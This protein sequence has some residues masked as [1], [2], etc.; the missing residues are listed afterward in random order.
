MSEM[1]SRLR[2]VAAKHGLLRGTKVEQRVRI[3]L[4]LLKAMGP[5]NDAVQ[6]DVA[7]DNGQLGEVLYL[8]AVF[9]GVAGTDIVDLLDTV[10]VQKEMSVRTIDPNTVAPIPD[11]DGIMRDPATG[12]VSNFDRDG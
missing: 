3:W 6:V 11:K 5:L 1:S 4:K 2:L 10:V 8:L 7:L 9:C 12:N